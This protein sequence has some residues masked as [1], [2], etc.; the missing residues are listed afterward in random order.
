MD[1]LKP[2]LSNIELIKTHLKHNKYLGCELSA[3]NNVL[4][5]E[6]YG[7]RFTVIENMLVFAKIENGLP[8]MMTFPI[9]GADEKKAFDA[10]VNYYKE[11]NLDFKMYLVQEKMYKKIDE[12]YPGR[13]QIEYD[14]DC[15]D[16]L[17]LQT[18][19][20]D[21]NGKK[22]HGKRNHINR[23]V[24]KYPDYEYER[25][26]DSNW[27]DCLNIA[28]DWEKN[29]NEEMSEDKKY[30]CKILEYALIN[31]ETLG[32]Q[33]A[34]I[35]VDG[36]AIAFTL[37]EELTDSTFVIHFEKA[38]SDIQGAYPMINREFVRRELS[39]YKYINREED[40]GIEG[41]R[42]AKLSYQPIELVQKGMV[43]LNQ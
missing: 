14:R 32:L 18:T 41:L 9:G 23:F 28:I 4:W 7:T 24:E 2:D 25:I 13:Y 20:Q 3:A 29:N 8:V 10:I 43:T 12:W 19:L 15:A 11:N 1:F 17:Y 30:E 22:L 26:N 34:L 5:S 21:L 37:G 36:R 39:S 38:Y 16:Y 40:L 42:K 27:Q 35:R 33:G 31:R 6:Y